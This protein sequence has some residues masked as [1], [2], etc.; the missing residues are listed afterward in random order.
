LAQQKK[1]K[2]TAF[3]FLFSATM[4]QQLSQ[5]T[6]TSTARFDANGHMAPQVAAVL[7]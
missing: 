6:M 3:F 2:T 7:R 5:Q 4:G 1:N